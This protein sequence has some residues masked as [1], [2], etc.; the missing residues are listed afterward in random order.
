M[1]KKVKKFLAII[2]S[3]LL[4]ISSFSASI[5]SE[6]QEAQEQKI[7]RAMHADYRS[8]FA[9]DVSE[10]W[11]SDLSAGEFVNNYAKNLE[12]NEK[13]GFACF[14][15]CYLRF[16]VQTRKIRATYLFANVYSKDLDPP[17]SICRTELVC[18]MMRLLPSSFSIVLVVYELLPGHYF[19]LDPSIPEPDLNCLPIERYFES[20]HRRFN[21][22]TASY[23]DANV[24]NNPNKLPSLRAPR[25]FNTTLDPQFEFKPFTFQLNT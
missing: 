3:S 12:E 1:N 23:L 16:L 15:S 4:S 13:G 19:V 24:C 10:G 17:S 14:S 2:F 5:N 18:L 9:F 20:L 8:R 22:L 6:E 11:T 25:I 21:V 7:I